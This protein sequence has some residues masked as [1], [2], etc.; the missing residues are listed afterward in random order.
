MNCKLDKDLLYAYADETID[1]LERIFVEEHLKYCDSCKK[2]LK[3]IYII[4]ENLKNLEEDLILP[5]RLR[6][7]SELIVENCLNEGE[8]EDTK[9]RLKNIYS[10]YLDINKNIVAPGKFYKQNPFNKF[11]NDKI[12]ESANQLGKTIRKYT[13][14]KLKGLSFFRL[15][16]AG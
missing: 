9:A 13:Y 5:E 10:L 14:K 7:I 1:P 12:N 8:R 4:D 3:L 16:K 11:I 2:D 15:F 6:T